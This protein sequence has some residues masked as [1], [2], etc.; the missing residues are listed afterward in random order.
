MAAHRKSLKELLVNTKRAESGCL[1]WTAGF[2]KSGYPKCKI[3]S[4][5]SPNIIYSRV[6]RFL[7]AIKLERDLLPEEKALHTCD[8]VAC[9]EDSHIWLGTQ[10]DNMRDAVK[11]GRLKNQWRKV[12]PKIILKIFKIYNQGGITQAKLGVQ[13]NLSQARVSQILRMTA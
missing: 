8:N 4:P 11:K 7:L 9:L 3:K 1:V 5:F 10:G 13:F 6:N 2:Y 12:T